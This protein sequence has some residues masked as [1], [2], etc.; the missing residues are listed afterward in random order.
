MFRALLCKEL[1]IFKF[2]TN[3]HFSL[4]FYSPVGPTQPN[5]CLTTNVT[6]YV[7]TL[8]S[9]SNS[10][11]N[12]KIQHPLRPPSRLGYFCYHSFTAQS[13]PFVR[14][15]QLQTQRATHTN[16]YKRTATNEQFRY[17]IP[18]KYRSFAVHVSR[19]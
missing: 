18:I 8:S 13:I 17:N 16:S 3:Q 12:V 15:L 19:S 2:E 10:S 5:I 9:E 14:D 1:K 7:Q 11:V 6:L 4:L